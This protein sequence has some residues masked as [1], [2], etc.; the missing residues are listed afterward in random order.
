MKRRAWNAGLIAPVFDGLM[1]EKS[2]AKKKTL[3]P[4]PQ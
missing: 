1:S 2:N 4:I 3:K